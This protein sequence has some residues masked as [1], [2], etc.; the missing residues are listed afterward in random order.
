MNIALNFHIQQIYVTWQ[1]NDG[2]A[3]LLLHDLTGAFDRVVT[4]HLL[5]NIRERK[6]P[7]LIVKWVGSFISNRTLTLC[8][9]GYNANAFPTQTGLP[10]GS[11]LLLI[12]FLSYNVY[13]LDAQNFL[14]LLYSGTSF[15]NN[16]STVVFGKITQDN[17]T[18]PQSFHERCLEW[19]RSHK[20]LFA[21]KKHFLVHFTKAQTKHNSTCPLTLH[22]PTITP[23]PSV[24]RGN[25]AST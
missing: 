4:A 10:Q 5:N 21:P 11:P 19:A 17:Y 12:C 14:T 16:V 7:E 3:T 15:V 1:N 18:L 6:A 20:A 2:V 25:L 23:G 8:L 22:T 24:S 13:H 9:P